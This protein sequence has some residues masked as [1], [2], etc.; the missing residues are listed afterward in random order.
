MKTL[1][2]N[3][4]LKTMGVGVG[5]VIVLA[6]FSY[7][8]NALVLGTAPG[9]IPANMETVPTGYWVYSVCSS[10][11]G[12]L[13]LA[14]LGASYGF[15]AQRNGMAPHAGRMALGGALVL[16]VIG[17]A[18]TA[19]SVFAAWA[20][21]TDVSDEIFMALGIVF[22]FSAY[23]LWRGYTPSMIVLSVCGSLTAYVVLGAI[24][25]AVYALI[26]RGRQKRASTAGPATVE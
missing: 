8:V 5:V 12:Y 24:G 6:V 17:A 3:A 22:G 1:D 19:A 7:G 9:E 15:F 26:A 18:S 14:L 21:T 2:T 13:L 10:C 25:G 11:L 23:D 16:L 20:A 4:L